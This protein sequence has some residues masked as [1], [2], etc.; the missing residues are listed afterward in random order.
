MSFCV[1]QMKENQFGTTWG[2]KWEQDFS[3]ECSQTSV[4]SVAQINLKIIE[5][6]R[7]W[8]SAVS[9][10]HLRT[11]MCVL[12]SVFA[13][14]WHTIIDFTSLSIN[15][16]PLS[17]QRRAQAYFSTSAL[18]SLFSS[19]KQGHSSSSNKT[20]YDAKI[21]LFIHWT[22]M[23]KMSTV[24]SSLT[25]LSSGKDKWMHWGLAVWTHWNCKED[26]GDLLYNQPWEWLLISV[27]AFWRGTRGLIVHS[28]HID[29]LASVELGGL[30]GLGM[31]QAS[32][33]GLAGRQTHACTCKTLSVTHF[34]PHIHIHTPYWTLSSNGSGLRKSN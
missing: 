9:I 3:F 10:C 21:C 28:C 23:K 5:F 20:E 27:R 12:F 7:D 33:P 11:P 26:C 29:I 31:S 2:C 32:G 4:Y 15:A 30:S 22:Q 8:N 1:P 18:T 19:P 17:L 6:Y 25:T 24:L 13:S 16:N 14:H 34:L